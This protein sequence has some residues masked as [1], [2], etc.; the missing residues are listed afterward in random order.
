[1]ASTWRKRIVAAFVLSTVAL[2]G[3]YAYSGF[4]QQINNFI[5]LDTYSRELSS[6]RDRNGQYPTYFEKPDF[7]GRPV[8]YQTNGTT[9]LLVSYGADGISDS[10][11]YS[12]A[13]TVVPLIHRDACFKRNRD[14]IFIGRE[15]VQGCA[16]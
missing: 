15:L 12:L 6:E 9:F 3:H 14:T 13:A 5:R 8:L 2:A 10:L 4:Y 7:W 11:E 16:K 1:M